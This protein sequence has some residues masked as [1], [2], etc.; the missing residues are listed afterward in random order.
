[1]ALVDILE[2]IKEDARSEVQKIKAETDVDIEKIK[3][4]GEEELGKKEEQI[5]SQVREK[6]EKSI[7]RVNTDSDQQIKEAVLQKKHEVLD[8]VLSGALK[9]LE[10]M[11]QK[12][13]RNWLSEIIKKIPE[14]KSGSVQVSKNREKETR[15]FFSK[16]KIPVRG[17]INSLGGFKFQSKDFEIDNTFEA[18]LEDLCE[19]YEMEIINKLFSE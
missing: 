10:A 9:K 4:E 7:F 11:D 16:I 15:D 17:T 18:V 14:L 2:K 6:I 3:K 13:Y 5:L 1:M 19:E 8:Q 12:S